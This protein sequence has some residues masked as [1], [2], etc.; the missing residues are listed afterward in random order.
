VGQQSGN[1]GTGEGD[2]N[3]TS[4]SEGKEEKTGSRAASRRVSKP[5]PTVDTIPPIRPNL[6]IVPLPVTSMLQTQ[7]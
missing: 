7:H 3:S 6:L 5:T 1:H 2:E 4:Y